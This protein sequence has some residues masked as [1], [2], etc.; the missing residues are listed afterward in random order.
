MAMRLFLFKSHK[1]DSALNFNKFISDCL[2]IGIIYNWHSNGSICLITY[3]Q[4]I[5]VSVCVIHIVACMGGYQR[6]FGWDIKFIDHLQVVTTNNYE[7]NTIPVFHSL[8][9]TTR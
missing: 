4:D 3:I 7:Y 5:C 2:C 6:V 9:P 1:E 8:H